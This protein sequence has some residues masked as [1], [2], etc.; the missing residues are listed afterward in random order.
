M[1]SPEGCGPGGLPFAL[2]MSKQRFGC[3][4]A[5]GGL[6]LVP[7]TP[8]NG[9]L[10]DDLTNANE[11]SVRVNDRELAKTPRLVLKRFHAR[12]AFGRQLAE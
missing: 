5:L 11:I 6:G 10:R 2:R 8:V 1:G 12:D 3:S 7:A 4:C 9:L